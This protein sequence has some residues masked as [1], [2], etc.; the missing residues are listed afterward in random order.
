MT[1]EI[2]AVKSKKKFSLKKIFG[3]LFLLLFAGCSWALVG[4]FK[5]IGVV[6]PLNAEFVARV[7]SD[8]MPPVGDEIY[9]KHNPSTEADV[10]SVNRFI[11]T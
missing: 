5:N 1:Q 3:V 6:K 11:T 4:V 10:S 2:S 8:K 9:S 7:L